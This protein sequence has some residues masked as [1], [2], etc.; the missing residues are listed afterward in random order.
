MNKKKAWIVAIAAVVPL[1]ALSGC[2]D[3]PVV[4]YK[5]GQYQGKPDAQPWDNERFKG[6]RAGW[7][8]A[9]KQRNLSQDEYVRV[10]G[11]AK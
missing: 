7:E 10:V 6:D 11:R 4:A 9:V 2:G 3:K 1:L 5:Q 8:N